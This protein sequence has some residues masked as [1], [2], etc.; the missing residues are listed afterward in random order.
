MPRSEIRVARVAPHCTP[1]SRMTP[2]TGRISLYIS[3]VVQESAEDLALEQHLHIPV[4][5]P[6]AQHREELQIEL[7]ETGIDGGLP[8]AALRVFVTQQ[9]ERCFSGAADGSVARV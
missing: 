6:V 8:R 3:V 5:R 4:P 1:N 9:V 7:L 2:G